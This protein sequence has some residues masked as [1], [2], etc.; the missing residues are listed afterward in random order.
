M[1]RRALAILILVFWAVALGWLL[2]R[3]LFRPQARL[4]AEAAL[5][6]SPGATYY[7]VLLGQ[8]QIGFATNKVDTL[9]DA[10]RV[11]DAMLLQIP[12]LGSLQRVDARTEA[13][14]T[15]SLKLVGF[16]ATLRSDDARFAATGT[17]SGDT[18]LTVE[19][20]SGDSPRTVRVPLDEPIVLPGPMPLQLTFGGGLEVG[21][22]YSLRMFDPLLL[23]A[24]EITVT[25]TA[26]STLVVPDSATLDPATDTWI[27][28]RWDTLRAWR[29]SQELSGVEVN[30]W[31]DEMGQI[32]EATSPM[33]FALRRTAFEIAYENFRRRGPTPLAGASDIIRGTAIAANIGVGTEQLR[34]LRAR[35]TGVD[36]TRFDLGGGR[37]R[38]AGDTLIVRREP[39]T[40]MRPTYVLPRA[41]DSLRPFLRPEPL[42]QSDDPRIQAQAR[43]IVGR[44]RQPRRAAQQLVRWVY[45]ELDKRV[46]VSVPNALEVLSSRAGDCNEH[47]VL[48]VALA[49][50]IG[51]PARTAA[52]LV[53]VD[54]AFYY[55]AWPEVYLGEW[56]AVDPTFDQ[57]PA[58]AA[59]LRFTIGGL[60]RQVE[61]VRL[62]GRLEIEVQS[63]DRQV[64]GP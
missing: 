2:R 10:I 59:H 9:T 49:R 44:E 58:D 14:L 42:I 23:A 62:I 12:A 30:A 24:R 15:R 25:V 55:H 16:D 64:Q 52:G 43:Q 56:V 37:Q 13:H 27:P 26:E 5:S 57:F 4:L 48:F 38:L 32:V 45:R 11:E 19:I 6:V 34:E 63:S 51:I 36:L 53:Y 22:R 35:L 54:D 20:T 61:L 1:N 28:A 3:E 39:E 21:K 31:I 7:Q 41:P 18:L 60:A 17:V 40:A 8:E 33:G 29:V 50:A 47:T 46:T